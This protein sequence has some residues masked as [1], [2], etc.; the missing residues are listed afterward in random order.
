LG[1]FVECL[2]FYHGYRPLHTLE[3]RLP[4]G[5]MQLIVTLQDDPLRVL[6]PGKSNR[7]QSVGRTILSGQYAEHFIIDAT[8][9]ASILGVLFRPGGAFPF[10]TPPSGEFQNLHLSMEDLWGD[11]AR[12]LR[13]RLLDAPSPRAKFRILEKTLLERAARPLLLHPA[14]A[15]ALRELERGPAAGAVGRVVD[16]IG[17]SSRR[18]IQLFEQQVGLT[19]KLF[20]RV[21]RFQAAVERVESLE[22]PDW[23]AVAHACGYFDQAHFIHDFR[24]FAGM[25]PTEYADGRGEDRNHVPLSA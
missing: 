18:F 16:R 14:V 5:A 2:W 24:E 3:R 7:M 9:Q 23:S 8:Q 13:D 20:S 19:P 25:T 6:E 17:L 15:F 21:R 12:V 1:D 11:G 22:R 10:F 4:T